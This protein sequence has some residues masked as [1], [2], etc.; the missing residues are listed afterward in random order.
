VQ[1]TVRLLVPPGSLLLDGDTAASF[2]ALDP[3]ALTHEWHHADPR[4]DAL[5]RAAQ[6]IV[7]D[8]GGFAAVRA[9]YYAA[10]GRDAP[11]PLAA[12]EPARPIPRLT[13][14]WFC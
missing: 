14:H 10:A 7:E 2:G 1:L 5:Q 8:G 11:A 13:E 6:A 4:V 9:A 12:R 3:A